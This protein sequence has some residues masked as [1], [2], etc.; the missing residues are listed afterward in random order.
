[1]PPRVIVYE[2]RGWQKLLPLVYV[3]AAFQL[4]CG[5]S[6]LVSRVRRLLPVGLEGHSG[7][8]QTPALEAWCRPMLADVVSQQTQLPVNRGL[9]GPALLLNGRGVWQSLPA[10]DPGDSTWVG[11]AG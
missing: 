7:N 4:L 6:D 8:G 5:T 9:P 2:D 3:R 11:T 1:M 10:I